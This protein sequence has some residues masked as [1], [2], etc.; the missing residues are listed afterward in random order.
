MNTQ[1]AIIIIIIIKHNFYS[2]TKKSADQNADFCYF[3][4]FLLICESI[5][6]VISINKIGNSERAKPTK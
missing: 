1:K 5:S 3:S 2:N 6:L 4:L